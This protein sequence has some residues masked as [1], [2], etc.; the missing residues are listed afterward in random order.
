MF[1]CINVI[2]V[3]QSGR[4]VLENK[5]K[6]TATKNTTNNKQIKQNKKWPNFGDLTY[7][8]T[9]DTTYLLP[10]TGNA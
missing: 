8:V 3:S 5:N 1:P 10:Y 9:L 7:Q 2:T 6:T 4:E